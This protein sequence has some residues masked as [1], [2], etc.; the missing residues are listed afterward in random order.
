MGASEQRRI[1][2][3]RGVVGIRWPVLAAASAQA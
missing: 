2:P 3:G 1:A